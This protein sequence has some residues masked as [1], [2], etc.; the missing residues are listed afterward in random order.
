MEGVLLENEV[1]SKEERFGRR[2]ARGKREK[3]ERKE[4]N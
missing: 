4:G 3:W 1:Q 2:A